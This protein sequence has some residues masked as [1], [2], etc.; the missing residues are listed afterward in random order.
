MIRYLRD[1]VELRTKVAS[2]FPF[3]YTLCIYAYSLQ[4]GKVNW[5]LAILFFISMLCLDMAT[6]ALNHIAGIHD[7][8]DISV[9][10]QKL[11]KQMKKLKIDNR[12][13]KKIVIILVSLGVSLGLLIMLLSSIY[14]G[15]VGVICIF[16]AAIYSYGPLPLKNTCLGEIA[17]GLTMGVLIPLAFLLSQDASMFITGNQILTLQFDF[18]NIYKW[19]LLLCIP[20]LVIANVMLAN[21]T[22]D[23]EKD[24]ANGR[25]TL[26]I[27]IGKYPSLGLWLG[28]YTLAY[29]GIISGIVMSFLP[30]I[31]IYGL[32]TIPFVV[33]NSI[34]FVVNPHKIKTFKY[35]VFNLQLILL[36]VIMPLIIYFIIS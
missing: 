3:V 16:V 33:S 8:G 2:V 20:T 24:R 28:S 14:V 18:N 12:V 34:K 30:P 10:D 7:E 32:V 22:C 15:L 29:L 17:S 27:I 11:L 6:T 1:F 13:N 9:Y 23:I 26:P 4:G 21:N 36:S 5:P 35:A 25:K 19:G 31:A